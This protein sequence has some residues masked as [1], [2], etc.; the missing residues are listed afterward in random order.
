MA[1]YEFAVTIPA[2]GSYSPMIRDLVAHGA[3]HAGAGDEAALA[4]GCRAED[5]IRERVGGGAA[6]QPLV[7]TVH[8]DNGPLR[9]V[10]SGAGAD[11][12]LT[13]DA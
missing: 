4:F 7:V 13:L 6:A 1:P 5:A 9:V 2:D 12:T 8:M 11:M 3:R 10:V